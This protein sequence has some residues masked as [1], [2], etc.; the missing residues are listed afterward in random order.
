MPSGVS[1]ASA[2]VRPLASSFAA[3]APA[4]AARGL[5]PSATP[6][7]TFVKSGIRLIRAAPPR[8]PADH[9]LPNLTKS[10]LQS[11]GAGACEGRRTTHQIGRDT[12]LG[13]ILGLACAWTCSERPE[14]PVPRKPW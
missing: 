11:Q 7:A 2:G 9:A 5:T 6:Y 12:E 10:P 14:D 13:V 3:S 1:Q 8:P 4:V